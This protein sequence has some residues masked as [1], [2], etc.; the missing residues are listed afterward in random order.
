[1]NPNDEAIR[2]GVF[3]LRVKRNEL[4]PKS[5][6]RFIREDKVDVEFARL[7]RLL[8]RPN[9]CYFL[10]RTR[11]FDPPL[12]R[13]LR[14]R[15]ATKRLKGPAESHETIAMKD[16]PAVHTGEHRAGEQDE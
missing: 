8:S 5:L 9:A 15:V 13:V 10:G 2:V 1:M 4:A 11:E 3:W 12:L 6:A 14:L 16:P 7:P